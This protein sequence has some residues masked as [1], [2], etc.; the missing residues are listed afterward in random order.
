MGF[1][2]VVIADEDDSSGG[3]RYREIKCK[4]AHRSFLIVLWKCVR[5]FGRWLT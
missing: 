3:V 1:S 5:I 2:G 4:P